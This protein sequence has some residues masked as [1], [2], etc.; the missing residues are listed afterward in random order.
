MRRG[1]EEGMVRRDGGRMLGDKSDE[2]GGG[3][4]ARGGKEEAG[5]RKVGV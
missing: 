5:G 1:E 3:W 2:E 4:E